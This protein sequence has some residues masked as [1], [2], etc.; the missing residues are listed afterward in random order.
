[1]AGSLEGIGIEGSRGSMLLFELGSNDHEWMFVII[2]E[3]CKR[4]RGD[5]NGRFEGGR[6]CRES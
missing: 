5:V 1:M 6:F 3:W 4:V 2:G